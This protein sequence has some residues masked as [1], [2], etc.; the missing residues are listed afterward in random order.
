VIDLTLLSDVPLNDLKRI[1]MASQAEILEAVTATLASGWWLNG[2]ETAGFCRDFAA[3]IGVTNCLGVASGTDALEIAM[4]A[5]LSVQELAG[6]E[7]VTVANAGGYSTIACRLVG[8]TPVYA[9]IEEASQLASLPSLVSAIGPDTAFVVATHL[10]GNVLDVF[11]LRAMM[12]AAGYG[13]VA[14]L[15]DCAQA[16]GGRLAGHKAG[17]LGDIATFSFYPTKNLGAFGDGGAIVTSNAALADACRALHQY[18]WAGKYTIA[19][20][21]GRNSRLDEVQATIL[22]VLLPGLE[23][24]NEK[25]Q[26]VLDRYAAA[27]PASVSL[28]RG[29]DEGVAHLA[30]VLCE[31][32]DRFKQHLADWKIQSDI[33]YPILD[34]DQLGWQGLPQRLVSGGLPVSRRSVGRLLTLPCFPTITEEEID[35]VCTALAGWSA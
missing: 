1:Y 21:G 28:V 12:D 32:R 25:R 24:A 30:V 4:R 18:G 35:R 6:S 3:Y 33:H 11:S 15:E 23:S 17:A 9:D 19:L 27:M 7:V 2:G 31:D 29:A 14:I 26:A 22:R 8:L 34:C 13:H 16:H 10:Y 20:K 5:L